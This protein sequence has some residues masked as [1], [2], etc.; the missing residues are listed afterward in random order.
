MIASKKK[1]I[2]DWHLYITQMETKWTKWYAMTSHVIAYRSSEL[3]YGTHK[4]NFN[5]FFDDFNCVFTQ[6]RCLSRLLCNV[7]DKL[8]PIKT[9]LPAAPERLLKIIRCNCKLNCDSKR[10]TCR[11]H[12][13]CCSAGCGECRG[14][15]CSNS[16]LTQEDAE[17]E[18]I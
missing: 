11:K 3:L 14:V 10:C 2:P 18:S 4:F 1:S 8:N 6:I 15:G 7:N 17:T 5:C 12:G 13:L 16:R 9:L